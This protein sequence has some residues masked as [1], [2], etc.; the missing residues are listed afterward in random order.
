MLTLYQF[1]PIFQ[2]WLL[3]IVQRFAKLGIRPNHITIAAM[4]LSIAVGGAIALS[5]KALLLLPISL[6]IRMALNAIDGLLAREHNLVTPL[7]G[8]LNELGDGI[9]DVALYLPFSLIPGIAAPWIVLIVI[10]A[11]LTE[12]AGVLGE[13]RSYA[14]PMGKS[15]R[16]LV[17]S[18]MAVIISFGV[19][20]WFN[21]VWIGV[22]G[23]EILTIINRIRAILEVKSCP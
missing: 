7:G 18:L 22:L 20:P 3:P 15:D 16:A 23:L 8:I 19:K 14:G 9:S 1:K 12:F 6:L 21:A 13:P 2:I 11:L 10:F 4:L 17:F 5:P